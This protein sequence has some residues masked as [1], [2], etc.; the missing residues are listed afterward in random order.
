MKKVL[1]LLFC[2]VFSFPFLSF[3]FS[4]QIEEKITFSQ[5]VQDDYYVV[6]SDVIVNSIVW[7]D[8]FL[9]W[10]NV[11]LEWTI[12]EDLF[13]LWWE[14]IINANVDD[15]LRVIWITLN[16]HGNVW[17]DVVFV[18]WEINF[19]HDV[20][21][22]W[23][24]VW[25]AWDLKLDWKIVQ[26]VKVK[27]SEIYFDAIVNWNVDLYWDE[28][29][30]GPNALIKWN[31]KY[32]SSEEIIGLNKYVQW[33]IVYENWKYNGP[34]FDNWEISFHKE[35]QFFTF[36]RYKFIFLMVFASLI[37]F[38]F[39]KFINKVVDTFRK[40]VGISFLFGLLLYLVTPIA[41]LILLVSVIATP[42]G[43]FALC[44][45]IFLR[46]FTKLFAVVFGVGFI[47]KLIWSEDKQ[48]NII[49][50]LVSIIVLSLIF[51]LLPVLVVA[52]FA[53]FGLWAILI[54]NK[55][56]LKK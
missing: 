4:G 32:Q 34:V 33:E 53:C 54:S 36:S 52:I 14:T 49:I 16:L 8:L 17:W 50:N 47:K 23:D 26:D 18:W 10:A 7:W 25:V 48:H 9:L 43:V 44:L 27:W 40:N 39:L 45:Y 37:Y 56:N 5:N 38:L 46:A 31:L 51:M 21:I 3:W 41:I 6:W 20:Q 30:F 29:E 35:K 55:K 28:I 13:L 1:W 15:D 12:E 24:L 22:N 19:G 42:I 2:F 11:I